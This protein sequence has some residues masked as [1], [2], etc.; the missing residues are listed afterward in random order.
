MSDKLHLVNTEP[1]SCDTEGGDHC[2]TCS[3]E[4]LP[5]TVLHVDESLALAQVRIAGEIMEV[6]VSLLDEVLAGHR[7]LVHGGVALAHAGVD[8]L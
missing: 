3:D 6:D 1:I 2:V 8:D 7:I 4:A 5:A